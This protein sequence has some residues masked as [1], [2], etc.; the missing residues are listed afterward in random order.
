[1]VGS[2]RALP[3]LPGGS[4]GDPTQKGGGRVEPR[5]WDA[6]GTLAEM[7]FATLFSTG[8]DPASDGVF[9][10]Q[11]LRRDART[12]EWEAFDRYADPFAHRIEDERTR[13]ASAR[14]AREF[15]VTRADLA[16]AA[17]SGEVL[18]ELDAF[19][20]GR[21]VVVVNRATYTAWAGTGGAQIHDLVTLAA[22]FLPG[23]LAAAGEELP[24]R[25]LELDR[26]D[27]RARRTIGPAEVR[28]CLAILL[29]RV[30]ARD[31]ATLA[32][33]GHTLIDAI[34]A[35]RDWAPERAEE[36]RFSLR[37]LEHPSKWRGRAEGLYP[38][39]A[40]LTDGKLSDAVRAFDTLEDALEAATPRWARTP[41]RPDPS[42]P[43]FTENPKPLD[44]SDQRSIDEIFQEYLPRRMGAA[45]EPSYR[46]GQHG[47]AAKI[48]KSFG[49][50]ELTLMHAPTG[51]GKTLAYLVPTL[52]WAYRNGV[53][54]GVATFTR[55]LQEQAMEH[56]VPV[57][58]SL[59]ERIGVKGMRVSL[60]KGRRNYL[61]WR[62]LVHQLPKPDA[63]AEELLAWLTLAL[64]GLGDETGDLDRLALRSPFAS[65]DA[66]D[67][68]RRM[69]RFVRLVR[70]ETGCCSLQDDRLTCAAEAARKR[71]ERSHL[72]ISNHA[73]AMARREFFRYLVFDECEHL[74]DV[75]HNAFSHTVGVRDLA[76]LL[77]RLYQDG[78]QTTGTLG[79][80]AEAAVPKSAAWSATYEVIEA[81]RNAEWA[82]TRLSDHL[83]AFK[84]WRER[85]VSARTEEDTHS[86][87]REYV[88]SDDAFELLSAHRD[89]HTALAEMSAGLQRLAEHLDSVKLRGAQR[90]RRSL[91]I[92]R[93]E[94]DDMLG[95]VEAWIPRTEHARPAFR[96]QTF[97]DLESTRRGED[98]LAA[99][100]LLP[101]EFLGRH[102]YPD[103]LGA[104]FLSA[105]TWLKGGFDTAATFL[106]LTR[107]VD[108]APDEDREPCKL[109][110]YR[111]PEAFDYGRVLVAVPR[112]A[113]SVRD[114]RENYLGYV[115][116]FV[117]YLAERTRGRTLV[118]FTNA[119]DLAQ[120]GR[121]VEPFFAERHIPFWYQ[122]MEGS[123][124][125]ELGE[126]FRTHTDSVLFGL[127][128][129]WYGT[130]FP[131]P[132]LE[133]L[134][135]ARVPYGVPD[136]YHKAQCAA[137]GAR[138]QRRQIYLPRAL[139]KFRQGFGRLMRRESDKGCVFVLDKRVVDPRHRVF[140]QELPLANALVS[141]D[142]ASGG[143]SKLVTG[144]TDRCID[145]ALAHMDMKAD[146][147]RRGLAQSFLGWTLESAREHDRQ[148]V[149]DE[150]SIEDTER[151]DIDSNPARVS[152]P[153]IIASEDVPF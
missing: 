99:R 114:S 40:E 69:A 14:M 38:E 46:A 11:A 34:D 138:E 80:I 100:V 98:V 148:P 53:R 141:E 16:G 137:L 85:R 32:V 17:P 1:M 89:L 71:A 117:A 63:P 8:P 4:G 121:R 130:D 61:C 116:R 94:L 120:V 135:I 73:F 124:K 67:W 102:Y 75:A 140:L 57:A 149:R 33:L 103:L 82:L 20:R 74:H 29:G 10:V 151:G 150:R 24:T 101:H 70:A 47:V 13:V 133:Y 122:R 105:T 92:Q 147:R 113:P 23:R 112:D 88:E 52:L 25:L 136:S 109:S 106:G 66:R 55:A 126:L 129:F 7:A 2:N 86:L 77:G 58:L 125:E 62:A 87:F 64:F 65:I 5:P 93:G 76:G 131:G 43:P 60:L 111:A 59:L 142:D 152:E 96:A 22:R 119:D 134:V 123:S 144:E 3:P 45:G 30:L 50:R 28:T 31:E 51:T 26:D 115:A 36:L 44:A 18:A 107:A 48:A 81:R 104:V 139:A 12:G 108:P 132:T 72:V 90:V 128:T 19:L 97:H 68:Q 143:R 153:P 145:T 35:L 78:D 84:D 9:R 95:G 118:L 91:E 15:G 21:S 54:V 6:T 56:D 37:L 110:T 39:H 41:E 27:I 146:V 127:D 83:V 79:R 49:K 42:M